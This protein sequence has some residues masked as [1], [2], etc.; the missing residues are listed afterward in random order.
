MVSTRALSAPNREQDMRVEMKRSQKERERDR[1][2]QRER[3]KEKRE[4]GVKPV[5]EAQSSV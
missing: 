2:T 4:G 5:S 1:Q 3:E